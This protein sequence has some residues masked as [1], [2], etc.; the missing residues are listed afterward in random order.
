LPV[1]HSPDE[2]LQA[3]QQE[4]DARRTPAFGFP[5]VDQRKLRHSNDRVHRVAQLVGGDGDEIVP[6]A[7]RLAQIVNQ[8]AQLGQ[9][10]DLIFGRLRPRGRRLLGPN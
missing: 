1:Q 6:S 10:G 5:G 8:L 9:L 2:T 7:H 4:D 3:L